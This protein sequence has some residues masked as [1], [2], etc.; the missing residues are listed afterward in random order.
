MTIQDVPASVPWSR[1]V[2]IRLNDYSGLLVDMSPHMNVDDTSG[3]LLESDGIEL[4]D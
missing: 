3:N 1:S 2:A 4:C